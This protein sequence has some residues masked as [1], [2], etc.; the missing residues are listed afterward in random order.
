VGVVAVPPPPAPSH[1]GR[2]ENVQIS[3]LSLPKTE[4]WKPKTHKKKSPIPMDGTPFTIRSSRTYEKPP[5]RSS[6]SRISRRRSAFPPGSFISPGSGRHVP[7]LL[8][9]RLQRRDR[10]GFA[11]GSGLPGVW[12]TKSINNMGLISCQDRGCQGKLPVQDRS[13]RRR[14]CPNLLLQSRINYDNLNL[15]DNRQKHAINAETCP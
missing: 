11:P 2:G 1:Q 13:R 12:L 8:R 5:G 6:G 15:L 4:N 7:Y 3:F 10:P 9:P 14:W